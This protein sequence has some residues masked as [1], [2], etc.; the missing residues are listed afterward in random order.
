MADPR[1]SVIFR[2]VPLLPMFAA[3]ALGMVRASAPASAEAPRVLRLMTYNVN[4]GNLDVGATLDTIAGADAD[5]VLLQEITEGWKAELSRRFGKQYPHQVFHIHSRAAG[6]LAVLS[7][8][9]IGAEHVLPSPERGWFPA[10]RLVID[11][12]FGALQILHVH[13]R[14]AIANGSWIQGYLLTPPLRLREIESYWPHLTAGMPT[15]IAGDFNEL[16]SGSAIEFLEKQGFARVPTTGPTTWHY[17]DEGHDLLKMDIDHVM[18]DAS[19][20]AHDAAVL[21]AGTSDHRPIVVT[22]APRTP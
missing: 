4:Y 15:I 5:I 20:T 2:A 21:D 18:L 13:L 10:E 11:G 17:V 12:P 1:I 8:H 16:P 14:P 19:L 22:I 3:L 7:K 9:P 6:G